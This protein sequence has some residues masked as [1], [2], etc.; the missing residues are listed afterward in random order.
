MS[1]GPG[2]AAQPLC[3]R[4]SEHRS[5][6]GPDGRVMA[7]VQ[8]DD[9]STLPELRIAGP[10]DDGT[11]DVRGI[12]PVD[13]RRSLGAIRLGSVDIDAHLLAVHAQERASAR[14]GS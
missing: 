10:L 5:Q 4:L 12:L 9:P 6:A 3:E 1:I 8:N 7:Q 14:E 11:T 2:V 13:P